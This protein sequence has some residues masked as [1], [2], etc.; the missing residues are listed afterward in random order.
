MRQVVPTQVLDRGFV[1]LVECHQHHLVLALVWLHGSSC[2]V[3][4]G[5]G[6]ITCAGSTAAGSSGM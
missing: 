2:T 5:S 3:G 1:S 4:I 6:C